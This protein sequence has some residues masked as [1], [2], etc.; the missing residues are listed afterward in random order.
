MDKFLITDTAGNKSLTATMFL[1]GFLI[2]NAKFLMS[3]L[4]IYG[5]T[6]PAFAG[7]DYGIAIAALGGVYVLRRNT[8]KST[9]TEKE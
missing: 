9:A 4:A 8:D 7:S 3:G 6:A 1:I 5:W 2:T